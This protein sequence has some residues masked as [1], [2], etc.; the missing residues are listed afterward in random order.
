MIQEIM[1]IYF[2]LEISASDDLSQFA[3]LDSKLAMRIVT[4]IVNEN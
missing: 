2:L 3:L 1:F 4:P